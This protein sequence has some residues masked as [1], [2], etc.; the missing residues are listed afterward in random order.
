MSEELSG[1]HLHLG[2][3][4]DSVVFYMLDYEFNVIDVI[5]TLV[6]DMT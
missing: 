3:L 1:I 6:Y 2:L 5:L 4:P